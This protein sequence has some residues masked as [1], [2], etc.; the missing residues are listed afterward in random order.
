MGLD[1]RYL[2][3]KDGEE[4]NESD[5]CDIL[6]RTWRRRFWTLAVLSTPLLI[7]SW[8][9]LF[10]EVSHPCQLCDGDVKLPY[11]KYTFLRMRFNTHLTT[12]SARNTSYTI[13]Q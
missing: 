7:V 5:R 8:A 9:L 13:R 1:S 12:F 6:E 11:C 3:L 2:P 10:W 4:V